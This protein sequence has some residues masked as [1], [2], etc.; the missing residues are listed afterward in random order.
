MVVCRLFSRRVTIFLVSKSWAMKASCPLF[1]EN[2]STD[3]TS[4]RREKSSL[5]V[6]ASSWRWTRDTERWSLLAM[7]VLVN[8][9]VWYCVIFW[10]TGFEIW[11]CFLTKLV[12]E[13]V[14]RRQPLHWNRRFLSLRTVGMP[15]TSR[16][17][18]VEARW[19]S[20]LLICPWQWGQSGGG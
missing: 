5:K 7:A 17:G 3:R 11:Q 18:I 1:R 6:K 13:T 12:S 2:S 8:F 10:R 16:I 20:Y 9:S 19:K 15:W 4:G 14:T